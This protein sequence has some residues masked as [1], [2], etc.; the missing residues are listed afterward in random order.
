MNDERRQQFEPTESV[1]DELTRRLDRLVDGELNLAQQRSLLKAIDATPGGWK[2]CALAFLESRAWEEAFG[3]AIS[4]PASTTRTLADR[5]ERLRPA[6]RRGWWVAAASVA[7]MLVGMVI[8][9][10]TARWRTEPVSPVVGAGDA[11]QGAMEPRDDSA[12]WR[13]VVDTADGKTV[14]PVYSP[15]AAHAP[16]VGETASDRWWKELSRE[17]KQVGQPLDERRR[18]YSVSLDDGRQV[19][20]PV[21]ELRLPAG[22]P[23]AP[24]RT[25]SH[26]LAQGDENRELRR[27]ESW[28]RG[29]T[30]GR[31]R[32]IRIGP[33]VLFGD[34]SRQL[35]ELEWAR[36]E[37]RLERLERQLDELQALLQEALAERHGSP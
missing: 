15:D 33:G 22:A 24:A 29:T 20:I 27:L 37:A 9:G 12:A 13:L 14:L 21:N 8:G 30:A 17:L 36:A 1:T 26:S 32:V 25:V 16:N 5:M 31:L 3:G 2:R 18:W 23:A 4:E 28:L 34:P 7:A 11:R 35:R 19:L 10:Q 6:A